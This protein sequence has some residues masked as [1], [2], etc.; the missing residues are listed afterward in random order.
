MVPLLITLMHAHHSDISLVKRDTFRPVSC[1]GY[2]GLDANAEPWVPKA[3]HCVPAESPQHY[4]VECFS[5]SLYAASL[6]ANV[7]SGTDHPLNEVISSTQI[8]RDSCNPTE[9]CV[10]IDNGIVRSGYPALQQAICVS[11]DDYARI[12]TSNDEKV[13]SSGSYQ[14]PAPPGVY[15]ADAVL[16]GSTMTTK[17]EAKS[18]GLHALKNLGTVNH[19]PH[20]AGVASGSAQ[21]ENC[22]LVQLQPVPEGVD[23]LAADVVID[24]GGGTGMLFL[25]TFS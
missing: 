5:Q 23:L 2:P 19:V 25:T 11:T 13:S 17:L 9:I 8:I 14:V 3:S 21:C 16:T 1:N 6:L 10:Q 15:L 18:L 22:S 20:Y 7:L 12:A 4:V 24:G